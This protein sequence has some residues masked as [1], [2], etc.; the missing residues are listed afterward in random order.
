MG[1]GCTVAGGGLGAGLVGG[2]GGGLAGQGP[3][4]PPVVVLVSEGVQQGLEFAGGGGLGAL[5]GQP[6]FEGLL[7]SLDFALGLG[8][9]GFPVLLPDSE[10]AQLGLEA[11]AAPLPPDRRV[12]KTM[13][14]SVRVAAGGP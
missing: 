2:G 1:V 3:V 4:R 5:G 11:V 10:A 14:L 8:V 7:E 6:F 13:P 12:V 9:V